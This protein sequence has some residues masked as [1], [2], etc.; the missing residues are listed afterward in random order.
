MGLRG[1]SL[2]WAITTTSVIGFSL[3]GFDQGLMSGI[4]TGTKFNEEFPPTAGSSHRATVI[5][6]AVVS[7]YELGCFFGAIF[8]LLRG[9][10]IG[11]RP[12][13]LVGAV[14]MIIGTIISI[15]PF[16]GHWA[17]GQFVVGRVISGLGNG[18]NTATIPVWQS[19]MS[20]PKNRGLLVN[21]E[22]TFIAVGTL[23]AYW[24][25]FGMSYVNSSVQWRFPIAFQIVFALMVFIGAFNLPESPRW[26]IAQG[27][28]DEAKQVL[29]AL[30][31]DAASK[32]EV[33]TEARI[34]RDTIQKT[35]GQGG[36]SELFT[37]GKTQ[38]FN[39]MVI[40][41]STQFFQQ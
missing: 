11:R 20:K 4:I 21:L 17:L 6:G 38:H 31:G 30:E 5:Q 10:K 35:G 15:T 16:K 18:M 14:L 29:F 19:E 3:F 9:E 34:I 36:L 2:R 13:M 40:G 32:E 1:R 41:A 22:G 26:L 27:R 7:C 37:N 23:V 8:T 33:E 12:L 24:L 28:S 25:D 39:R